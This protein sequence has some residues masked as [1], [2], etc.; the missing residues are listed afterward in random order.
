MSKALSL[1]QMHTF[2]HNP[3]SVFIHLPSSQIPGHIFQFLMG[4]PIQFCTHTDL[5]GVR[6]K[7]PAHCKFPALIEWTLKMKKIEIC[8]EPSP[9]SL[10]C[11][12]WMLLFSN[13]FRFAVLTDYIE[14]DWFLKVRLS[15]NQFIKHFHWT[16]TFVRV[17]RNPISTSCQ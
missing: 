16:T 5:S 14:L 15:R 2:G 6:A 1:P 8:Y 7:C 12:Q 3:E 11:V 9:Y 13:C 10:L 4:L 17:V